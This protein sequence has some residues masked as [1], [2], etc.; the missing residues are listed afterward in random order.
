M[1]YIF[2]VLTASLNTAANFFL[3]TSSGK[4]FALKDSSILSLIQN[5]YTVILGFF[6]Y[7]AS[8][9]S[10]ILLLRL[11]PLSVAYPAVVVTTLIAINA[12]SQIYLKETVNAPQTIGYLC[13]IVGI[14]LIFYFK[15]A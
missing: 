7:A 8:A 15:P 1:H 6:L 2:I 3:K 11:L 4:S 9:I 10:Y 5:H 12:V 14:T 13:L